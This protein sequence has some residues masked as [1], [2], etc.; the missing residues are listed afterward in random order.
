MRR[1]ELEK[2]ERLLKTGKSDIEIIKELEPRRR[3][4]NGRDVPEGGISLRAASRKYGIPLSTLAYRRQKGWIKTIKVTDNEVYVCESDIVK[5]EKAL[6]DNIR[7]G[8][9]E[10]TRYLEKSDALQ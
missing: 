1:S 4:G 3:N 2:L 8:S 9:K 7:R 5:I 6:S 10:I